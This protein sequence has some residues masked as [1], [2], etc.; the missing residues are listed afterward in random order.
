MKNK[1]LVAINYLMAG[2]FIISLCCVDSDTNAFFFTA[3]GSLSY[4]ALSAYA[5]GLIGEVEW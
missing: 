2:I 1:I 4:L 3:L 5:N